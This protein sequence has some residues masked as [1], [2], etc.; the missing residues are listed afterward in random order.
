MINLLGK[1][2]RTLGKK[3]DLLIGIPYFNRYDL[4]EKNISS[5]K[6]KKTLY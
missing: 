1:M 3:S 6:N 2:T 5:L 4:L